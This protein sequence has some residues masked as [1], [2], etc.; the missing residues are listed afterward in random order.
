MHLAAEKAGAQNPCAS[1][2]ELRGRLPK[3]I[4]SGRAGLLALSR[5]ELGA[6]WRRSV[7]SRWR[8]PGPTVAL[9]PM[10]FEAQRYRDTE[11]D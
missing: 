7:I 4:V 5:V 11:S 6:L 3:T 1:F 8:T 10:R 2:T 9:H